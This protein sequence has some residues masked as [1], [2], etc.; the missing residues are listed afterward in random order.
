MTNQLITA[1]MR[2][3]AMARKL[4]RGEAIDV[5]A[6]PRE[7]KYY[8]LDAYADELDYCDAKAEQWIWSIGR[9]RSDGRI[10]ASP[11]NDL[12]QNPDFECLWLR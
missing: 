10:L 9:R 1:N 6:F 5:S 8:V 7:G 2:N 12:Y 3:C 11:V 4:E